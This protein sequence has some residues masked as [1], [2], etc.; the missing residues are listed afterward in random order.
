MGEIL[1]ASSQTLQESYLT[2]VRVRRAEERARD[3]RE[4]LRTHVLASELSTRAAPARRLLRPRSCSACCRFV[5]RARRVLSA[6]PAM[7]SLLFSVLTEYFAESLS[8]LEY[9]GR[10]L[11]RAGDKSDLRA[12]LAWEARPARL[13]PLGAIELGGQQRG[14]WVARDRR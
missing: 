4:Q 7:S 14:A 5:L 8:P 12:A 9:D 10:A 6:T 13:E 3:Q 2:F 11:L 1:G